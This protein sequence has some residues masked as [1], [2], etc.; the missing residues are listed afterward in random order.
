MTIWNTSV[1]FVELPKSTFFAK[2]ANFCMQTSLRKMPRIF[3][4]QRLLLQPVN[5]FSDFE[6]KLVDLLDLKSCNSI[7]RS[8]FFSQR[9]P[10]KGTKEDSLAKILSKMDP[11]SAFS[12]RNEKE[13]K[14]REKVFDWKLSDSLL[15]Q[16]LPKDVDLIICCSEEK[17]SHQ[18]RSQKLIVLDDQLDDDEQ[19]IRY[20]HLY[21]FLRLSD[22]PIW[23]RGR[24][25]TRTTYRL[26]RVVVFRK[27]LPCQV[28]L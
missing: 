12:G 21:I 17:K 23:V 19:R 25:V 4:R 6:A 3:F 8:F 28:S 7:K 15:L 5:P 24:C 13:T 14:T 16:F 2:L 11:C 18:H 10:T 9:L 27:V 20:S 1:L 26:N 22:F